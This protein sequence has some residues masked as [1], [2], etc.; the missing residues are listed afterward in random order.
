MAIPDILKTPE[1]YD[2]FGLIIFSYLTI[3]GFL[4]YQKKIK[5]EKW[6][7]ISLIVIGILGLIVDG[8]ITS[9]VINL[10]NIK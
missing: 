4:W 10:L 5:L 1:F 6:I 3:I 7:P 2:H 8:S 9:G